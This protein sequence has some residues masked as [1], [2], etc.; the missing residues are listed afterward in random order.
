MYSGS[1]SNGRP[2]HLS[3]LAIRSFRNL[4]VQDLELPPGG[5]ALIGDNAQGKSN[6]L[7]AIYYLETL[8]SFRKTRDEHLVQ[9]GEDV[10][11]VVGIVVQ[12]DGHRREITAAY[13]RRG[14]KKVS[15][16]GAEP[17]RMGDA[18]GQ[19]AA[20]IFSPADVELVA[21]G[22]GERRRF[23]DIVLS[24]SEPRYLHALQDYRRILARRN[25]SLKEGQ[26]ERVVR[27]WDP[28]LVG[29]GAAVMSARRAWVERW[30]SLFCEYYAI[31]SGGQSAS[32]TYRPSIPLEGSPS[33]EEL[34]AT[35]SERLDRNRDRERRFGTTQVGPHRD[36]LLLRLEDGDA[37]LDLRRYGSGGERRTAAL[38]LR[39]AEA[40]TIRE[41]RAQEPLIL[42]DDV[43]A[44]LDEGRGER[45]LE[46]IEREEVGQ[47][48]VT[49]PKESDVR[50]RRDSLPRWRIEAGK[51]VT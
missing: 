17:E 20:V 43:F 23:L 19:L 49:A 29:S 40:R 7:E 47:V 27:A 13:E 12:E 10:F 41:T 45:V 1:S 16:D 34:A 35:F 3:R 31:V 15:V 30:H 5:V 25:A 26:P 42:L 44:E 32:L 9:F 18:L 22:A 4:G 39:L 33:E 36:D 21:G 37:A 50:L 2:A 48:V 14:K 11:R 28:G 8:K 24:L 51:I 46:L 38:A 6:F